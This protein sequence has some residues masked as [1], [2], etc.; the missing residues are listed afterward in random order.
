MNPRTHVIHRGSLPPSRAR[1]DNPK[2][3]RHPTDDVGCVR[4]R[5]HHG[6]LS[7]TRLTEL[8]RLRRCPTRRWAILRQ[9]P[10]GSP[11]EQAEAQPGAARS[12]D[13]RK[14]K[15]LERVGQWE[16]C[17]S[18]TI[19][20]PC[21]TRSSSRRQDKCEFS[22]ERDGWMFAGVR[23]GEE[24]LVDEDGEGVNSSKGRAKRITPSILSWELSEEDIHAIATTFPATT[25]SVRQKKK[26]VAKACPWASKSN[27]N[28]IHCLPSICFLS[29]LLTVP[30]PASSFVFFRLLLRTKRLLLGP[31]AM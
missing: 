11:V 30:P 24:P 21:D 18:P 14:M 16:G 7:P 12:N 27:N 9:P 19:L 1:A 6:N 26:I 23:A 4:V 2:T 29:S 3:P 5:R 25:G 13:L 15:S 8:K 22:A 20:F 31:T 28:S 10:L 17:T